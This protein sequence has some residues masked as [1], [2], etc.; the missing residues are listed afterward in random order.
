M[1]L[2]AA[3]GDALRAFGLDG[4]RVVRSFDAST[5][6]DNLLVEDGDGRRLV[7]RRCTRNG[8]SPN[9]IRWQSNLQATL[10]AS[11]FP[12]PA[13]LTTIEGASVAVID[14]SPWTLQTFVEG[15]HYDFAHIEQ[16]EEAG[17][18]LAEFHL[19]TEGIDA[20]GSEHPLESRMHVYWRQPA[21]EVEAIRQR[22]GHDLGD[23][24]EEFET[25][26]ASL[27]RTWPAARADDLPAG[28]AHG[29]Y[30]GRNLL[31]VGDRITAVL[32][33]DV[34]E[35]MPYVLDVSHGIVQFGRLA[36]GSWDIRVDVGRR[37]VAGYESVR[38]LTDKERTAL[39]ALAP[40]REAPLLHFSDHHPKDRL[41][42]LGAFTAQLARWR[43]I[44]PLQSVLEEVMRAG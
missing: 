20:A 3:T 42:P 21:A 15:E 28:W 1:E 37:L 7:L 44:L 32:D 31:F 35:R 43:R 18:R 8:A 2:D 41:D 11:G 38:P 17:R 22:F 36:R 6:N 9:R 30:H 25:W 12:V 26:L 39:P 40:L 27:A 24:I 14:G 34:I 4:A 29:D 5:Q 19:A 13:V 10:H 23:E 16:A 33:F